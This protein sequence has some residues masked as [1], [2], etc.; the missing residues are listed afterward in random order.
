MLAPAPGGKICRSL[1]C[2]FDKAFAKNVSLRV[3]FSAES[4]YRK[5]MRPTLGRGSRRVDITTMKLNEPQQ[6]QH[7]HTHTI[8]IILFFQL[9]LLLLYIYI[10]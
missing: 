1:N 3:K 6:Q 8:I 7:T 4:Y 10:Y 9:V 5:S 2:T